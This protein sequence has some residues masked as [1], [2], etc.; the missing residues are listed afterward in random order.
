MARMY[1]RHT[2]RRKDYKTRIGDVLVSLERRIQEARKPLD[3]GVI[4]RQIGRRLERNSRAADAFAISRS[5][6]AYTQPT[7][8]CRW[9]TSL[10]VN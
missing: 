3:R 8:C 10:A 7:L 1:S 2:T 4:E 6:R 9:P 5:S